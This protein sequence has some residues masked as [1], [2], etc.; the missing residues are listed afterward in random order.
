LL[1]ASGCFLR[2]APFGV[3]NWNINRGLKLQ[4]LVEFLADANPD[5]ILLLE[6]DLNARRTHRP[7]N[8]QGFEDELCFRPRV[9]AAHTG[10][11][12]VTGV[13]RPGCAVSVAAFELAHYPIR[14]AVTL[15][16]PLLVPT[17]CT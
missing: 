9:P 6:V 5:L 14:T 17:T 2:P 10:F 3:M 11:R 15:L 13:S 7:R 4:G 1:R 12:R 8:R 16:E